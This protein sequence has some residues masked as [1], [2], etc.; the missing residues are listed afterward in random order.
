MYCEC[1]A[2]LCWKNKFTATYEQ[3]GALE[4]VFTLGGA[5][6]EN[7]S[8]LLATILRTLNSHLSGGGGGNSQGPTTKSSRILEGG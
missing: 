8:Q 1:F 3:K 6:F 2:A 4:T 7:R 5:C